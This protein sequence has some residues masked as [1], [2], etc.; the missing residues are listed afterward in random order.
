MGGV[1]RVALPVPHR[2]RRHPQEI[3]DIALEESE[4]KSSCSNVVAEGLEV[5]GV[6][7]RL[8]KC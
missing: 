1:V 6:S 8:R 2:F 5:F 3:R 7:G 4:I